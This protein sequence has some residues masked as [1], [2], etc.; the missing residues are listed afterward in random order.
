MQAGFRKVRGC[1]DNIL[2][3]TLFCLGSWQGRSSLGVNPPW[4]KSYFRNVS[5]NILCCTSEVLQMMRIWRKNGGCII[6]TSYIAYYVIKSAKVRPNDPKFQWPKI[7]LFLD[8]NPLML[9]F[10]MKTS[11]NLQNTKILGHSDRFWGSYHTFFLKMSTQ[12]WPK[13]AIPIFSDPSIKFSEA[14]IWLKIVLKCAKLNSVHTKIGTGLR[15]VPIFD[16]QLF[17]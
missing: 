15:P 2:T 12:I 9:I 11:E 7:S 8:E 6:I 13:S 1:R 3:L 17:L 16:I 5:R 10:F 14:P 4:G